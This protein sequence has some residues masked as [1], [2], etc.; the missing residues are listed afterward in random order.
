MVITNFPRSR[1]M[2]L[3]KE[4]RYTIGKALFVFR[5]Y[6]DKIEKIVYE[7]GKEPLVFQMLN[8]QSSWVRI[9][10]RV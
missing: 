3:Q 1:F 2:K 9:Y 5:V 8:S 7:S 6:E 4:I 10:E